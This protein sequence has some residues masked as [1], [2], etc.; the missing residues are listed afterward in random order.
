MHAIRT[1]DKL[2][3][4]QQYLEYHLVEYHSTVGATMD[5]PTPHNL[6]SELSN[7]QN[8]DS[9]TKNEFTNNNE[10]NSNTNGKFN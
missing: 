4:V 3:L 8:M 5:P 9:S 2:Q 6:P 10:N 1:G 7:F